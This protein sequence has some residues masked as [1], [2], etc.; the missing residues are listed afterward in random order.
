M[1]KQTNTNSQRTHDITQGSG[2]VHVP[3]CMQAHTH[4]RTHSHAHS[5][6]VNTLIIDPSFLVCCSMGS[7]SCPHLKV[8]IIVPIS[9]LKFHLPETCFYVA[10]WWLGSC[11]SVPIRTNANP[12][13][14]TH[15]CLRLLSSVLLQAC[16]HGCLRANTHS[17][18]HVRTE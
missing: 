12:Y 10:G 6:M 13:T 3:A 11:L 1:N 8:E 18:V 7:A 15:S 9:T 4:P 16:T 5:V 14:N 17:H 2:H